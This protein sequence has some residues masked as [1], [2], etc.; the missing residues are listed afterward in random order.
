M[1]ESRKSKLPLDIEFLLE[2]IL[3]EN[4]N[5]V[6]N[7]SG[8]QIAYWMNGGFTFF[9]FKTFSVMAKSLGND[10]DFTHPD[11]AQA[12]VSIYHGNDAEIMDKVSEGRIKVSDIKKLRNE[13]RGPKYDSFIH[14]RDD[15]DL[16]DFTISGRLW[17]K[18]K[19]I[20]FWNLQKKVLQGWDQVE[21]MFSDFKSTVGDLNGYNID[22]LERDEQETAD[23]TYPPLTPAKTV[24][25]T[26]S[27]KKLKKSG[28]GDKQEN[29]FDKL[30]GTIHKMPTL[31]PEQIKRVQAKLHTLP[32]RQKKLALDV[33][34]IRNI[35]AAEIADKIGMSVVQFNH[36]MH[37]GVAEG[38]H[39][40]EFPRMVDIAKELSGK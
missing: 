9:T 11:L 18:R 12:I 36:L 14:D 40:D 4:P 8:K 21:K 6:Y 26:H 24:S 2:T 7:T 17:P 1:S 31:S 33:L 13:L 22:W 16:R 15:S 23:G 19:I 10:D 3:D 37:Q 32:P 30:F 38:K 28:A 25:S 29:F 5:N 39:D 27:A 34:G 20:S 35:K